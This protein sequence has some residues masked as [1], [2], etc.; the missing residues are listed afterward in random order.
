[1]AAKTTKSE[2][3]LAKL[4]DLSKIAHNSLVK[5]PNGVPHRCE[6]TRRTVKLPRLKLEE[7]VGQMPEK[8][9]HG[10]DVKDPNG[11]PHRC[12]KTRR[13]VKLPRL[14]LEELVA[15]ITEEHAHGEVD[16]GPAVGNE[17]G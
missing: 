16:T 2:K 15:E 17:V 10:G 8:N 9:S 14:K 4:A 6:K 7:L 13:T 3:A 11:V 5:D 1:M 12:E